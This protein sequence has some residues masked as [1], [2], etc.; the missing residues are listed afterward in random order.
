M[1][2]IIVYY[3]DQ[4]SLSAISAPPFDKYRVLVDLEAEEE[5]EEVDRKGTFLFFE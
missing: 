2:L 1:R 4:Y 5:E 3:L